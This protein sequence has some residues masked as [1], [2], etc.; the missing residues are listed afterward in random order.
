MTKHVLKLWFKPDADLPN[1]GGRRQF[2]IF[3]TDLTHDQFSDGMEA[4]AVMRGNVLSTHRDVSGGFAITGR[5]PM[6]IS[7]SAVARCEEPNFT[8]TDWNA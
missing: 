8:Y 1:A 5:Q 6:T 2:Y 7:G 4:D 3:E